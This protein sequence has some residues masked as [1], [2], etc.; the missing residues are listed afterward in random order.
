MNAVAEA[1]R[2]PVTLGGARGGPDERHMR[3]DKWWIQP[4]V[5][6]TVLT[7][8]VAYST[9]A[10]FQNANYFVGNAQQRDLLSPFYSPCIANGCPP[11]SKFSFVAHWWTLS[12]GILIL[13]VPLGFRLTCYYYRKAYYRSFWLSPPACGVAD[14]HGSYSGESRFPLVLQNIHRWFLYLALIFNVLLTIDAVESFRMGS[15]GWGMSMGTLVLCLNATAL[16][17]YTLSCHACRHLCGGGLNRFS[18]HPVRHRAWKLASKLN[19]KHMQLA[20]VSLVI[21]ALTDV[22]VRLVASGA[23][24]DPRFF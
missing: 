11:G 5:T 14:A 18:A 19:A 8:F 7:A 1:S 23:F 3:S 17:F 12:P 4:A 15:N 10:V 20:W 21:V 2:T 9:W 24:H 13:I 16:W 6:F 22:Y